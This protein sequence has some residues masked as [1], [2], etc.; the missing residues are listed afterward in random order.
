MTTRRPKAKAVT[1]F[2]PSTYL[3]CSI[4][5]DSPELRAGAAGSTAGAT[6]L[7]FRSSPFQPHARIDHAVENVDDEIEQHVHDRHGQHKTLHR[8]EVRRDQGFHRIGA[9]AGPGEHL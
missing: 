2:S 8:R 7:I 5:A 6:L 1:R 9:D 4:I 3:T